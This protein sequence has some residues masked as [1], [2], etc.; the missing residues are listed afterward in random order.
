MFRFLRSLSRRR[1]ARDTHAD[2]R[3]V[4]AEQRHVAY[5]HYM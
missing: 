3:S 5:F 2:L 1:F 4:Q